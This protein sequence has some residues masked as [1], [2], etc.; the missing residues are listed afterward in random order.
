MKPIAL[1]VCLCTLISCGQ[2]NKQLL[3]GFWKIR[4]VEV[5]KD[6]Q[7]QKTIDVGCQYWRFINRN[8]ISI[9]DTLRVQNVLTVK[10]GSSSIKS[11]DNA[12][13]RLKDEFV[14]RELDAKKLLL[15]SHH[16]LDAYD[17]NAL[18]YLE[19]VEGENQRLLDLSVNDTQ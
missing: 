7:L 18:Y 10:I 15:C 16:T 6:D 12:T 2:T 11:F 1:T 14:I 3:T 5:L 9:F 8:S 19:R 4:K 17:Y 13:D